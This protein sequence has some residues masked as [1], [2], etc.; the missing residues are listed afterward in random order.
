MNITAP[1]RIGEKFT[2]Q[3][4]YSSGRYVLT[5]LG[6]FYWESRIDPGVT[7]YAKRDPWSN[8]EHTDFYKPDEPVE[9]VRIEFEVP[10]AIFI[11]GYPL[12]ELGLNTDAAGHVGGVVLTEDAWEYYI[13]YGKTY[14]GPMKPMRTP[15][16]DKLFAPVLPLRAVQ[17]DLKDFLC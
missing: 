5:G 15:E 12:R 16:L 4:V 13:Y 9:G 1:C 14:G 10:D 6:F 2:S 8:Q 17:V 7:L 11:P 3:R